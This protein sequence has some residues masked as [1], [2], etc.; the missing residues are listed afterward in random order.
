MME[1]VME[2]PLPG[3]LLREA[4]AM[5]RNGGGR[6]AAMAWRKADSSDGACGNFEAMKVCGFFSR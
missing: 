6:L 2:A 3:V 4:D 5:E 1:E